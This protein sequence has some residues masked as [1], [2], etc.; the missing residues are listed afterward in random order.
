MLD[1]VAPGKAGAPAFNFSRIERDKGAAIQE[2]IID[3]RWN[4][5]GVQVGRRVRLK[6]ADKRAALV[7]LGKH[8]GLCVERHH[9]THD[10]AEMSDE[11]IDQQI[12]QAADQLARMGIDVQALVGIGA[13]DDAQDASLRAHESAQISAVPEAGDVPRSRTGSQ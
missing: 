1:Y 12:R 6:L 2:L 7:D 10:D 3:E 9:V 5:D 13:V 8:L 11:Q 4:G